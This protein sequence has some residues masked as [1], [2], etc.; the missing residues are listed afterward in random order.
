LLIIVGLVIILKSEIE[1]VGEVAAP[2]AIPA[3][4]TEKKLT[5]GKGK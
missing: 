2:E 5:K 1:T 3:I 4:E